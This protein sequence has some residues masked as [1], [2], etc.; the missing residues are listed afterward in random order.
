[1]N[2]TWVSHVSLVPVMSM[3]VRRGYFCPCLPTIATE[4]VFLL[5]P[6]FLSDRGTEIH[7]VFLPCLP[8]EYRRVRTL[9]VERSCWLLFTGHSRFGAKSAMLGIT[10]PHNSGGSNP[11]RR[12]YARAI[13]LSCNRSITEGLSRSSSWSGWARVV[14]MHKHIQ[15]VFVIPPANWSGLQYTPE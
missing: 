3:R 1:M 14:K 8:M 5:S 13:I 4:L 15:G 11:L 9:S 10:G 6:R 2:L 7:W 12:T